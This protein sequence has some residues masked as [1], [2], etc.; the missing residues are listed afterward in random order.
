[1]DNACNSKPF[2]QLESISVKIRVWFVV[3]KV[4]SLCAYFI[5][6]SPVVNRRSLFVFSWFST[7]LQEKAFAFLFFPYQSCEGHIRA[8][9]LCVVIFLK[10]NENT[11]LYRHVSIKHKTETLELIKCGADDQEKIPWV[12]KHPQ[13]F[14]CWCMNKKRYSVFVAIIFCK[15]YQVLLFYRACRLFSKTIVQE[16]AYGKV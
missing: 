10:Y 4:A 5:Y 14:C 1:M 16:N 11:R 6:Q 12:A 15:W 8:Y 2:L 9:N 13:N 7:A 3:R